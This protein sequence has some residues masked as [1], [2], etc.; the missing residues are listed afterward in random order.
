MLQRPFQISLLLAPLA[1]AIHHGEEHMLFNF[2]EWRLRYFRDTNA[3]STEALLVI[4]TGV[5]LVY[6]LLFFV[7]RTH[8]SA[9]MA[10]LFL[11]ASQVHNAIFHISGTVAFQPGPDHGDAALC[12][13]QRPDPACG[14]G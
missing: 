13:G 3:L 2:R 9:W 6:I 11:M 4:L 10:I 5:T 12:S 7:S 8:V 14:P 1:Y